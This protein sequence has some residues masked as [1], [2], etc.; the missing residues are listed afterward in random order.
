MDSFSLREVIC[1]RAPEEESPEKTRAAFHAVL[2][3]QESKAVTYLR[4]SFKALA[5]GALF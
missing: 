2:H 3:N 4:E 5:V 1:R